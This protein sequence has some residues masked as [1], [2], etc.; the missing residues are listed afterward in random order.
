M[1]F[2]MDS[3]S[4]AAGMLSFPAPTRPLS[5]NCYQ[6]GIHVNAVLRRSLRL[7]VKRCEDQSGAQ[8]W[9]VVPFRAQGARD[10][11]VAPQGSANRTALQ[12]TH[13]VRLMCWAGLQATN[14]WPKPGHIT[15]TIASYPLNR[16]G[17][18]LPEFDQACRIRV[19]NAGLGR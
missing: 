3:E 14:A 17:M 19:F 13:E 12:L 15:S 4:I 10:S 16:S 5:V 7:D 18:F 1:Y 6:S 11:G 9:R 8:Y 2:G